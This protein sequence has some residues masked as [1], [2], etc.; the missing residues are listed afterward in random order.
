MTEEQKLQYGKEL[1]K[2]KCPYTGKHCKSWKCEECETE[3][4]ER[5]G[6]EEL[7]RDEEDE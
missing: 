2:G 7:D 5:E 6:L 4:Q 3:K 1:F